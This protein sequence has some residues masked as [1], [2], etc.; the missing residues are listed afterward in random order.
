MNNET[1]VSRKIVLALENSK[2]IRG[3][4]VERYFKCKNPG[5]P[6]QKGRKKHG[7]HLYISYSTEKYSKQ[8]YVP[9]EYLV[10]VKRY[11]N[12]YN[13]LWELIKEVS[14]GNIKLLKHKKLSRN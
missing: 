2:I 6:C 10:A 7:P 1:G 9:P 12:N 8:I 4:L 5:C 3:S 11:I 14:M 13:K